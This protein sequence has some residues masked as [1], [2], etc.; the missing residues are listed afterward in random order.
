MARVKTVLPRYLCIFILVSIIICLYQLLVFQS[1]LYY[2]KEATTIT[3]TN[4]HTTTSDEVLQ[5]HPTFVLDDLRIRAAIL[6]YKQGGSRFFQSTF[7]S[8]QDICLHGA[9][10]DLHIYTS[11]AWPIDLVHDLNARDCRGSF[12][13]LNT[14]I[15]VL[16]PY[17]KVFLTSVHRR[18]FYD[19]I[20]NYDL[21][22]YTEDDIP[23]RPV[24]VAAYLEETK[25]LK[26]F[27]PTDKYFDYS[28]GFI[29]YEYK[30]NGERVVWEH[31]WDT[32]DDGFAKRHMVQDPILLPTRTP[33][34]NGAGTFHQGMYM[35]TQEQLVAW[36]DR[37]NF[38]ETGP[39]TA[40]AGFREYVSS[41]QLFQHCNVTQLIP[42][43]HVPDFL[44]HHS[45][46]KQHPVLK[47]LVRPRGSINDI[48]PGE[49]H[50][51]LQQETTHYR[52][53]DTSHDYNGIQMFVDDN[54]YN[55]SVN[56]SAFEAY[57]KTG[58]RLP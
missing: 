20:D 14:T 47:K 6:A 49:I 3:G 34:F 24:H 23:I 11:E 25:K 50:K 55:V 35:A 41:Q 40:G 4:H 22:V 32:A 33:Y 28:I 54:M 21:F 9:L 1:G 12:G 5:Q 31:Y 18:H 46:D 15:H 44:L 57:T 42:A 10:V 45:G 36:R 43:S 8:F 39:E 58:G 48:A 38:N 27:L 29:R 51:A 26:D 17:H 53:K 19:H 37:C 30:D 2:L 56:L 52:T 16:S 13:V 7:D